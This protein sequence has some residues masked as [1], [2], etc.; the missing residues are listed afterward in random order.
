MKARASGFTLIE[1]MIAVGIIGLLASVAIPSFAAMQL[2][3]RQAERA[4]IAKAIETT[5]ND[6]WL[7]QGQYPQGG[8]GFNYFSGPFNPAFPPGGLKRPWNTS[9]AHGDWSKLGLKIEGHVYHSYYAY[10]YS[11]GALRARWV[12]TYGDLDGDGRYSYLYHYVQNTT[13]NGTQNTY[14]WDWDSSTVD[15]SF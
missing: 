2:R 10:A 3:A 11:T 5:L 15:P 8:P 13:V 6:L 12:Y 7:R 4:V 14:V 1:L 9:P